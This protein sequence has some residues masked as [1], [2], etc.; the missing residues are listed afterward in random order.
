M[1]S[2]G[3][4]HCLLTMLEKW[5]KCIYKE[6]VVG[7]LLTGFSNSFDCVDHKLLTKKPS[8]YCFNIPVLHLVRDY[9]SNRKQRINI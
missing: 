7:A 5:K 6:K 4:Q 8:T 9:L 1:K 3:T 2:Y